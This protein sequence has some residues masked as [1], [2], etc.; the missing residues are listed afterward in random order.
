MI[1][2]VNNYLQNPL[3]PSSRLP[4]AGLLILFFQA[5]GNMA[6][7][8]FKL[9][10]FY[11]SYLYFGA[12]VFYLVETKNEKNMNI[13]KLHQRVEL[14]SKYRLMSFCPSRVSVC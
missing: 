2:Y 13:E 7:P 12:M 10:L 8:Q 14:N 6:R 5:F 9:I 11:I 3:N 4:M 1:D